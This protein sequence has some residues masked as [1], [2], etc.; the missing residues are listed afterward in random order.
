MAGET[1]LI[2]ARLA[3]VLGWFVYAVVVVAL[4]LLTL[5]FFLRLFGASTEAEF[6]QWVYRSVSRIMEPFR[7]I[8]PSEELDGESVLDFSLLFAMIIYSILALALHSLVEWLSN[9]VRRLGAAA[10]SSAP[11]PATMMAPSPGTATAAYPHTGP[12]PSPYST[13]T[14]P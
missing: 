12:Q 4:V 2:V 13:P 1:R 5:A 8:F 11:G 6:T 3:K 9:R 14:R 7:G 10:A